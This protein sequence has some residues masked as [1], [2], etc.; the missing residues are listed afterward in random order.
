MIRL[1]PV[2]KCCF[3]IGTVAVRELT[4]R[5]I[6]PVGDRT[7]FDGEN[8]IGVDPVGLRRRIGFVIQQVGMLAAV[9]SAAAASLQPETAPTTPVGGVQ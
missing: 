8:L 3:P 5:R 4:L 1:E 2:R 7:Y 9:T 6:E